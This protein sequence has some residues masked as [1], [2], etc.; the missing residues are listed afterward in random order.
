MRNKNCKPER[1]QGWTKNQIIG[2]AAHQPGRCVRALLADIRV[3]RCGGNVL[4]CRFTL[5][6]G[7]LRVRSVLPCLKKECRMF[8][9]R[10]F[11]P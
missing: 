1:C 2:A 7:I 11:T 5:F 6:K 3:N 8:T 4:V 10:S 9:I